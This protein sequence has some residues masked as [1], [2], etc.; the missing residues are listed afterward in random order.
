MGHMVES[1]EGPSGTP[2][3]RLLDRNGE[4]TQTFEEFGAGESELSLWDV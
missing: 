2:D 4:I 3:S 1:W